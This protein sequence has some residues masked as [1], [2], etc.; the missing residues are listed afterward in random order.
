MLLAT[1]L[2]LGLVLETRWTNGYKKFYVKTDSRSQF[3]DAWN[4]METAGKYSSNLIANFDCGP[5][6]QRE[7]TAIGYM[8]AVRKLEER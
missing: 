7:Y 1:L 6:S 4:G 3:I 8:C 5:S 2:F